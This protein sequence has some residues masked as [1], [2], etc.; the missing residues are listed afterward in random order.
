MFDD[1]TDGNDYEIDDGPPCP[2]CGNFETRSRRCE[3]F[4]CEDGFCDEHE[5]DP[6]NYAPGEAFSTCEECHGTGIERWCPKCGLDI[7]A[8]NQRNPIEENSG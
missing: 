4:Q 8:Y 2:Q 6:I 3:S 1:G 5:D 7:T